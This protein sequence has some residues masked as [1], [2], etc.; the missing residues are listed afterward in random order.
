MDLLIFSV[1]SAVGQLVIY[2]M[3]KLFKQHI[4]PFVIATRKCVTVVV[5]IVHFG[6][7]IN[8]K[9]VLGMGL[10]FVA[11]IIEVFLN[12]KEDDTDT[13]TGEED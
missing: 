5:N 6:H 7:T 12:M 9:Q 11:I 3:I 2:K 13:D 8:I 1:L 10:V 4:V